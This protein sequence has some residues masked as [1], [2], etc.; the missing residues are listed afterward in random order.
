MG[1]L[2]TSVGLWRCGRMT[3]WEIWILALG[4]TLDRRLRIWGGLGLVW[5]Y[6]CG[7]FR[8][9]KIFRFEAIAGI[10]DAVRESC[11][12]ELYYYYEERGWICLRLK[13][14]GRLWY[15]IQI[16]LFSRYNPPN[17]WYQV[18]YWKDLQG[19]IHW[20]ILLLCHLNFQELLIIVYVYEVRFHFH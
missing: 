11:E 4:G 8:F 17:S 6:T 2:A 5:G 3:T 15:E 1:S 18:I 12:D 10:V 9:E 16:N 20:H 13:A 14:I 19:E 7:S